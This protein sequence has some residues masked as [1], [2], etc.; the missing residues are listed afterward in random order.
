[1]GDDEAAVAA[2]GVL[3]LLA[4]MLLVGVG[5]AAS[6]GRLWRQRVVGLRTKVTMRSDAAWKAA[7]LAGGRWITGSGAVL[8][9]PAVA[10]VAL[11]PRGPAMA[12]LVLPA[13]VVVLV[14][15]IVGLMRGEA[16]ASKENER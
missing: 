5:L 14:L 12:Y 9:A 1:M 16:A 4:A 10:L 7:H 3:L 13:A 6:R 2:I 11:R 8:I 15:L